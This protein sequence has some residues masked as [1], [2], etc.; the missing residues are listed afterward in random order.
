VINV[1]VG[2]Q[3]IKVVSDKL[4][5]QVGQNIKLDLTNKY[6]IFDKDTTRRIK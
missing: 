4:D 6:V 5:L 1:L 2:T 3:E